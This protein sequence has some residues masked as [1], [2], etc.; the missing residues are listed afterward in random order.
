MTCLVF[1]ISPLRFMVLNKVL[2]VKQTRTSPYHP[3]GNGLVERF[4]RTL[5][6]GL[7]CHKDKWTRALPLVLLGIR[8]TVKEDLQC[9]GAELVYGVPLRL[10]AEYLEE[11][12]INIE[13][14]DFL[15]KFRQSMQSLKSTPT[16]SHDKRSIFIHPSLSKATHVFVR[17][18]DVKKSL[19]PPYNG[20]YLVMQCTDKTFTLNINGKPSVINID[21]LKPGFLLNHEP[22]RPPPHPPPDPVHQ[23][24]QPFQQPEASVTITVPDDE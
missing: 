6:Q 14:H 3:S 19:Q 24:V 11:P 8:E 2:G 9:T 4:H 20:P 5:K 22:D 18:D 10:P 12:A 23:P 17:V 13:P 1:I 21:R 15:Q 16:A 7:R